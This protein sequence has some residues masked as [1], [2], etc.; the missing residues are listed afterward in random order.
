MEKEL[1]IPQNLPMVAYRQWIKMMSDVDFWKMVNG[2]KDLLKK[3]QSQKPDVAFMTSCRKQIKNY[4][5]Y[6][7]IPFA[8]VLPVYNF[9]TA[10]TLD[11][12][13]HNSI[14]LVVGDQEV[15]GTT[16][17]LLK[18]KNLK[19]VEIAGN[20]QVSIVIS[21]KV[22]AEQIIQFVKDNK[23]GIEQWQD[24]YELPKYKNPS[25][26]RINLALDIIEMKDE[27]GMS[28]SEIAS[29]LSDDEKLNDKEVDYLASAE[30]IKTLYRRFKKYLKS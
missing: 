8:W 17:N 24:F 26:K 29:E 6:K 15:T 20:R 30:N 11:F 23:K 27:K 1:V 13:L 21:S 14:A 28:Y 7:G 12:P 9:I 22:S 5:S 10:N 19:T 18:I 16:E 25:W 3:T 4:L 2:Q